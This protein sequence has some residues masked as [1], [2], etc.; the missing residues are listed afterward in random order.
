MFQTLNHRLVS[1]MI[2]FSECPFSFLSVFCDHYFLMIQD[3][4]KCQ[5]LVITFLDFLLSG[6]LRSVTDTHERKC[7]KIYFIHQ[8]FFSYTGGRCLGFFCV[9]D[10]IFSSCSF[11]TG[12]VASCF[13]LL[14]VTHC[15]NCSFGW[16]DSP[17]IDRLNGALGFV[18]HLFSAAHGPGGHIMFLCQFSFIFEASFKTLFS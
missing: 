9:R 6:Q 4:K 10:C 12:E 7:G 1:Q 16:G 18:T 15:T 11:G 8:I 17:C 5:S 3:T 13:Q 2:S 14:S